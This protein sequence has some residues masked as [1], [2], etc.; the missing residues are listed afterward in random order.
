MGL[1]LSKLP[2]LALLTASMSW[3]V[4]RWAQRHKGYTWPAH[5]A[6]RKRKEIY[7]K[8]IGPHTETPPCCDITALEHTMAGFCHPRR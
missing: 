1:Q 5:P 3:Q 4:P 6:S 7:R 8:Y 2:A